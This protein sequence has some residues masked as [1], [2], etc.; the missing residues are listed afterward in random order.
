MVEELVRTV[1]SYVWFCFPRFIN[2]FRFSLIFL[3]RLPSMKVL[4][5]EH[6]DL[7]IYD[8][9]HRKGRNKIP[10]S[11]KYPDCDLPLIELALGQIANSFTFV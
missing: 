3:C 8:K 4:P 6:T 7:A 1:F 9:A 11:A 2:Q 10:C 5:F